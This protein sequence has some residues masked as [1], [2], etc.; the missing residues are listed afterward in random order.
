MGV[1]GAGQPRSASRR[2]KRTPRCQVSGRRSQIATLEAAVRRRQR[3]S[4]RARRLQSTRA[5][6]WCGAQRRRPVPLVPGPRAR[7]RRRILKTPCC[8][9][10]KV[11]DQVRMSRGRGR[12]FPARTDFHGKHCSY[13]GG[14]AC[15]VRPARRGA[16]LRSL[17]GVRSGIRSTRSRPSF[18]CV[19]EVWGCGEAGTCGRSVGDG[20]WRGVRP[21]EGAGKAAQPR[22]AGGVRA[23]GHRRGVRRRGGRGTG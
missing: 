6:R 7:H 12:E 17:W 8:A 14:W 21:V 15:V 22:E 19:G 5:Q 1:L 9:R 16:S 4:P 3:L 2:H 10:R 23:C 20:F 18:G 11:A 13:R